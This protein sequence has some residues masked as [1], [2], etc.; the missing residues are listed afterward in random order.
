MGVLTGLGTGEIIGGVVKPL[1][2]I[3]DD[4]FT[5]DEERAEAKRKL[6]SD[7]GQRKIRNLQIRLSAILAEANSKDPWTSR[8]RPSFLYIIYVMILASIPMGV[9]SAFQPE[10]AAR[11]VIGMQGWLDAIPESL[12]A[13]FGAGYLGYSAARSWDKRKGISK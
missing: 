12:W 5:S 13:L 8:A 9:L 2:D 7:D 6:L 3:I 4:L 1:F 10:I 11:I